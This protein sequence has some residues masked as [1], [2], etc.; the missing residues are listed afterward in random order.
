MQAGHVVRVSTVHSCKIVEVAPNH[1][2]VPRPPGQ[3]NSMIGAALTHGWRKLS[4]PWIGQTY[5]IMLLLWKRDAPR[6]KRL[7]IMYI[8]SPPWSMVLDL[9]P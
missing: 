9:D 4:Q 1:G 2:N 8:L 7:Q 3:V 5:N 6:M